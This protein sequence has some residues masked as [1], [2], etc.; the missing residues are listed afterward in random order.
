M[1]I[2]YTVNENLEKYNEKRTAQSYLGIK[3]ERNTNII[4]EK[5]IVCESSCSCAG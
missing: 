3:K 4:E 5:N 2:K 1:E